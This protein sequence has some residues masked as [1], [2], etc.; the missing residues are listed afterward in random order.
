MELESCFFKYIQCTG[1]H[2]KPFYLLDEVIKIVF[3]LRILM[4]LLCHKQN[5]RENEITVSL[6]LY[7]FLSLLS[8][9]SGKIFHISLLCKCTESF[10]IV[11]LIL[12]HVDHLLGNV[13]KISR[14]TTATT[15]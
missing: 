10:A 6:S 5:I 14:F 9:F 3:Q 7:L 2:F 8:S 4:L 13:L 15:E 11:Q 12:W 1:I